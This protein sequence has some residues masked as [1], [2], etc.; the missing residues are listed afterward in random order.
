MQV[1]L[2]EGGRMWQQVAEGDG[3]DVDKDKDASQAD[4]T[5]HVPYGTPGLFPPTLLHP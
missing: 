2:V 3:D 5:N 4:Q 1:M